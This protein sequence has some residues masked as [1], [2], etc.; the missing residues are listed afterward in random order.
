M[1][2]TNLNLTSATALELDTN[3]S[4][5]VTVLSG[6]HSDLALDLIRE[7][8][9]DYNATENPDRID[10][11]HFV[12]HADIEMDGKNYSIC[13]IRNADFIGDNRI[14]ANFKPNSL[15]F[16]IDDTH[17]FLD[18]INK[19]NEN[20]SN[21]FDSGKLSSDIRFSETDRRLEAFNRF[22]ESLTNDDRPI[23]IYDF[24]ERIDE[25]VDVTH[26]IN[27]LAS[28]GRQVFVA[29][30][31]NYPL[32]KMACTNVQIVKVNA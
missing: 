17:E 10:D 22:V 2:V 1:K 13:Y 15:E 31:P 16:S 26:Y 25:S 4:K 19:R 27:K 5:P 14:A 6:T 3:L 23:L 24:F 28:L 29:V 8:I 18:K 30:S 9:G 20:D 12:I 21:V 11:G 32:D 7:I